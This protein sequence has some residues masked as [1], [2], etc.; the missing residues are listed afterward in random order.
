MKDDKRCEDCYYYSFYTKRENRMLPCG[1]CKDKSIWRSKTVNGIEL[2]EFTCPVCHNTLKQVKPFELH[3][4]PYC[5]LDIDAYNEEYDRRQHDSDV[6]KRNLLE[7][8]KSK[9][10]LTDEE[11]EAIDYAILLIQNEIDGDID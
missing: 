8:M 4:C 3:H 2:C 6:S 5:A 1:Q 10:P 11:K 7:S 9:Y